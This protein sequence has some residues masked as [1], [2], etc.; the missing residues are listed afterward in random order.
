MIA[1]CVCVHHIVFIHSSADGPSGCFHVLAIVNSASLNR[2]AHV[3]FQIIVLSGY[4]SRSGIAGSYGK[5]L[6]SFV[7]CL[8]T[9][10]HSSCSNLHSHQQCRRVPFSPRSL[11]HLLFVGFLM[12]V[13]L[14]HV[15]WHLILVLSC[16]SPIIG[17]NE[18]LLIC[19]LAICISSL[20]KCLFRPSVHFSIASFGFFV[21]ELYE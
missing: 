13:I 6:F 7:R 19:L 20:E 12:M 8:H 4:R 11:Q 17:N 21:V 5:S 9:V 14:A 10:F 15:R 2:G 16:I 18:H 1:H 3:C